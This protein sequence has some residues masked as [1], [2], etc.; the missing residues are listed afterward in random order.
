MNYLIRKLKI[1]ELLGIGDES[2]VKLSEFLEKTF[3]SFTINEALDEFQY[4]N[5]NGKILITQYT[6]TKHILCIKNVWMEIEKYTEA[7]NKTREVILYAM[8]KYHNIIGYN[9]DDIFRD[10][11]ADHNI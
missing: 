2:I 10:D 7:F 1:Y 4:V 6:D 11:L 3:T 5:Y 9:S 8:C